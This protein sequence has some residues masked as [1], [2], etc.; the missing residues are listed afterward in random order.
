MTSKTAD[1]QS[2]VATV[3]LGDEDGTDFMERLDGFRDSL[4]DREKA[5]LAQMVVDAAE[6]ADDAT[7]T[8][9]EQA[10]PTAEEIDSFMKKLDAFH[11]ELPGDMHLLVD[12]MLAKTVFK[13]RSEVQGYSWIRISRWQRIPNS[14]YDAYREWC[15]QRGGDW[16]KWQ[17]MGP[18]TVRVACFDD[19]NI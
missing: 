6:V 10:P 13:D 3:E 12:E 5:I 4:P 15:Y 18:T 16:V 1:L 14:S 19:T 9:T 2:D 7:G 11:D 17:R 8:G